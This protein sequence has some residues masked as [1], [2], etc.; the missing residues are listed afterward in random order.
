MSAADDHLGKEPAPGNLGIRW[1]FR[2]AGAWPEGTSKEL[3]GN[4]VEMADFGPITAH[5]RKVALVMATRDFSRLLARELGIPDCVARIEM[6]NVP[7]DG[8]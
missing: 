4:G 5:T 6:T 2:L 1:A 3:W 7:E 8:R